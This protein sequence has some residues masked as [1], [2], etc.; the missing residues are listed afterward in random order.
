MSSAA[1]AVLPAFLSAEVGKRA[2]A[3]IL[4]IERKDAGLKT[5]ARPIAFSAKSEYPSS[6]QGG[7]SGN[8]RAA[9]KGHAAKAQARR[10]PQPKPATMPMLRQHQAK[11]NATL[12][13]Q[14]D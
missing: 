12:L 2:R 4:I 13:A 11:A 7:A 9:R 14:W 6:S 8:R 10:M 5:R 1:N 3:A